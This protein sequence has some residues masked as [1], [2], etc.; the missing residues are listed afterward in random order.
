[1][2]RKA[3]VNKVKLHSYLLLPDSQEQYNLTREDPFVQVNI[4]GG[5]ETRFTFDDCFHSNGNNIPEG[6]TAK[7]SV[8]AQMAL[9]GYASTLLIYSPP[10]TT[11][12]VTTSGDFLEAEIISELTHE[13][14]DIEKVQSIAGDYGDSSVTSTCSIEACCYELIDNQIRDLTSPSSSSIF[15]SIGGDV[16]LREGDGQF[17]VDGVQQALY[18]DHPSLLAMIHT[19]LTR[20]SIST[21]TLPDDSALTNDNNDV[22][23]VVLGAIGTVFFQFRVITTT[24]FTINNHTHILKKQAVMTVISL[25][26][27]D[28]L[29]AS[30]EFKG[31]LHS[32]VPSLTSQ[33]RNSMKAIA[34]LS[35]VIN[36]LVE[37]SSSED[38]G[39]KVVHVPFRDSMLTRLLRSSLE[40]STLS[41]LILS[42]F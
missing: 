38:S 42:L 34:T 27:N 17:F 32:L 1:M 26:T 24:S 6:L 31:T 39:K 20:R 25:A 19:A 12:A 33:L 14:Y 28:A 23:I 36:S 4:R 18:T 40:V 11:D 3:G 5:K 9:M 29:V 8:S 37:R 41:P 10:I 21:G 30:M 15:T 16:R 13:F 7:L 22:R 2:E 35:R